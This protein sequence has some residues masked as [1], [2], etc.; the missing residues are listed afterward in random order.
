MYEARYNKD[1][2]ITVL[3]EM[4]IAR[5]EYYFAEFLSSLE[6]PDPMARI[7]DIVADA[8]DNDPKHIDNGR[9]RLP[10]NMWFIGTANNDDSTFAISDKVYDR[11]MILNLDTKCEPFIATRT[12]KTHI[13]YDQ[14]CALVKEA[15][16]SY[17]LSRRNEER[18]RELDA[19]MIEHFQITFGNR[20][21]KQVRGYVPVYIAC[22][23]TELEALDDILSKKIMRKLEAKNPSQ[24][25]REAKGLYNCINSLF[26]TDKMPLC[27]AYI[28]RLAT[29]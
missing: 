8:W 23:G 2:Y 5:V 26:G 11:A 18:L 3:D 13:S 7:I 9:F 1:L 24:L 14:F 28:R 25:N 29:I 10:E 17:A 6:I 19:Y 15:Q 22:G 4:N 12:P 20:I 16:E 21:M 27:L